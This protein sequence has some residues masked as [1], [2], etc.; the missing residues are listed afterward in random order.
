MLQY[1]YGMVW[2]RSELDQK[3]RAVCA[4][5]AL[6]ALGHE[7]TLGE[8]IDAALNCDVTEAELVEVL[9]HT[10]IYAGFPAAQLGLEVAR[11]RL[12]RP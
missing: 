8:S 7:S 12:K 5:A 1:G 3:S 11:S 9:C 4:V 6:T 2:C 10:A